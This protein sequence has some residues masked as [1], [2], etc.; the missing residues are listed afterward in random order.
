MSH[1][2]SDRTA[3]ST[4]QLT[5]SASR[6][7]T[8]LG[9]MNVTAQM[10]TANIAVETIASSGIEWYWTPRGAGRVVEKRAKVPRCR[11]ARG[12]QIFDEPQLL[13]D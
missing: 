1:P 8:A 7:L 4:A 5:A 3:I 11:R 6:D 2:T 13:Y 12:R 9:S 10:N